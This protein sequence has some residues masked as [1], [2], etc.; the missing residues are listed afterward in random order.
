[1]DATSTSNGPRI[2]LKMNLKQIT[3]QQTTKI[4][5]GPETIR[6]KLRDHKQTR[7]GPFNMVCPKIIHDETLKKY[8]QRIWQ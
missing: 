6:N 8:P 1:M 3:E 4:Q 2:D 7:N 5:N